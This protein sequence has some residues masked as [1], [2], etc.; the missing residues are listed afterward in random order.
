LFPKSR[1]VNSPKA[2]D[3]YENDTLWVKKLPVFLNKMTFN[4]CHPE[5]GRATAEGESKDPENG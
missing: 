4:A 3:P 5:R 2:R 1:T